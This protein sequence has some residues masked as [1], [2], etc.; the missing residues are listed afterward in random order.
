MNSEP[1]RQ[2]SQ[3]A[4]QASEC[5]KQRGGTAGRWFGNMA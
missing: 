5:G 4:Q 1:E 3:D 2:E